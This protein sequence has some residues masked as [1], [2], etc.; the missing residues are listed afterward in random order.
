MKAVPRHHQD[1]TLAKRPSAPPPK[2]DRIRERGEQT[3]AELLEKALEV[4]AEID[5]EAASVRD[6]TRRVGVSHAI[7][8]HHFGSKQ[9]VWEA[10][11]AHRLKSLT[12]ELA[13]LYEA[14]SHDPSADPATVVETMF[15]VVLGVFERCPSL[16]GIV[17]RESAQ[18]SPR[19]DF[20]HEHFFG[21]AIAQFRR[22]LASRSESI[23]DIDPNMVMLYAVGGVPALYTHRGLAKKLGINLKS[24]STPD[25]YRQTVTRLLQRGL[26]GR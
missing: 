2:L 1:L 4:F 15:R 10:A 14:A 17:A 20:L 26:V 7:T 25:K 21:V 12:E 9:E 5:Y 11:L 19:L 24:A 8:R 23:R 16:A 6:I 13:H 22:F 18:P 3:R